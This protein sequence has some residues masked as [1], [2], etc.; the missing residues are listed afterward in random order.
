NFLKG[1]SISVQNENYNMIFQQALCFLNNVWRKENKWIN[2][3][4]DSIMDLQEQAHCFINFN[5][6]SKAKEVL[7]KLDLLVHNDNE[8]AM[9]YYL[10]GRLEQNKACF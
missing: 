4:S 9:H 10:K 8:L 5:E 6:N 7:D 1:L 3:E 2:F